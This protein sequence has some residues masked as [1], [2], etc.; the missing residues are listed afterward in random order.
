MDKPIPLGRRSENL[1]KALSK[2]S[3]G[4]GRNVTVFWGSDNLLDG[5]NLLWP[6]LL[7]KAL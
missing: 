2:D 7:R 4:P 5:S 6:Q 3:E 1:A